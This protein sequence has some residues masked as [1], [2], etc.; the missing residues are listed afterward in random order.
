MLLAVGATAGA[1]AAVADGSAAVDAARRA[2]PPFVLVAGLLLVGV[3]A[4][5]DGLFDAVAAGLERR[6]GLRRGRRPEARLLAAL[7]GVVALTTAVL[8]L[9]TSV[10]FLTPILV[11]AARRR[12]AAEETFLYGAVFMS[13]A[14]SLL[15]PGSNL[16]NL[17]VLA[18]SRVSG[19][20]FAARMAPAWAAAVATT[21]AVV[22]YRLVR[23]A[24]PTPAAGPAE[25]RNPERINHRDGRQS[26]RGRS[27]GPGRGD[28]PGLRLSLGAAAT[29]GAAGLVVAVPSP[30]VPVLAVGAGVVGARLAGR[31]LTARSVVEAVGPA[32][33]AGVYGIAVGLGALAERWTAPARVVA[34]S[35]PALAAAAG[36]V[37]AVAV[38]NLPAAVLLAPHRP[39]HP[40]GLL[41][42]LN[43]GPN[44]AVTGSLSALLWYQ[45]ARAVGVRPS[46]RTYTK[47]GVVLVPLSIAAALAALALTPGGGF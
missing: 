7:L 25:R 18:G 38:N 28:G 2:W 47:I 31:R 37:A 8:N 16:T 36:T 23:T 35:G 32:A 40:E 3:V 17:L 12:G 34:R 9:D 13:N 30:A 10:A 27:P 41:L 19:V 29:V 39:A 43:L 1:V 14:A 33:L 11:L 4:H 42:G 6:P 24:G 45:S 44:L 46:V 5:D 22:L 21:A 26:T 20:A 15:L